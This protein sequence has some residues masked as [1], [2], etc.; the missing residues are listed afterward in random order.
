MGVFKAID[1]TVF[2]IVL[3]RLKPVFLFNRQK[4]VAIF[5]PKALTMY[6]IMKYNVLEN[7]T[8]VPDGSC[9]LQL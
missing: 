1:L 6:V 3:L 8:H 9:A 7:A 5:K 4:C 2:D